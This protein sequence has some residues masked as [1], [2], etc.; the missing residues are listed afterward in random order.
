[1]KE[2]TL[3]A[4]LKRYLL[5]HVNV[6]RRRLVANCVPSKKVVCGENLANYNVVES[7]LFALV[8]L[9]ARYVRLGCFKS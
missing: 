5:K 4:V 6:D 1:M 9:V 2:S 3:S 8:V 7:I